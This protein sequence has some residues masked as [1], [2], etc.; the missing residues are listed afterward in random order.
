MKIKMVHMSL[1]QKKKRKRSEWKLDPDAVH[2]FIHA[3]TD[4]LPE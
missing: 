3:G 2:E 1:S 4:P